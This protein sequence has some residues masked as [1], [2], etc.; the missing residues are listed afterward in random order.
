MD[1]SDLS[2]SGF[3]LAQAEALTDAVAGELAEGWPDPAEA[4]AVALKAVNNVL[5]SKPARRRLPVA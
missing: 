1:T 2:W 3:S 5:I 4:F